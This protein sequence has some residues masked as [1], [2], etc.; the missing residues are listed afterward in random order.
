M[1]DLFANPLPVHTTT[2]DGV[3]VRIAELSAG[4]AEEFNKRIDDK[5]PLR[6]QAALVALCLR[7]A[8]GAAVFSDVDAGVSKI[9]D[10][11]TVARLE[12]MFRACCKANAM[13]ADAQEEARGN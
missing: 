6:T 7:D 12:A 9:L 4:R 3:E 2:V 11:W 10:G 5:Q 13:G 1:T 8:N